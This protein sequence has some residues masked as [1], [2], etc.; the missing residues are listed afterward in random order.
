MRQADAKSFVS[1]HCN[2]VGVPGYLGWK[3]SFFPFQPRRSSSWPENAPPRNRTTVATRADPARTER[4]K[5]RRVR[6]P[7]RRFHRVRLPLAKTT[8]PERPGSAT[9]G[10]P[11]SQHESNVQHRHVGERVGGSTLRSP[12]DGRRSSHRSGTPQ[13][14][15]YSCPARTRTHRHPPSS[16]RQLIGPRGQSGGCL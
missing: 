2:R 9:S 13:R 14:G 1:A 11:D 4:S 6:R 8:R 10:A 12:Q 5:R 16:N 7:A 3:C 15:P